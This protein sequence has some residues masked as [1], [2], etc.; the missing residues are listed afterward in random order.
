[1]RKDSDFLVQDHIKIGYTGNN[2]IAEIIERNKNEI[3]QDTLAD[4]VVEGKCKFE[5][6]WNINGEKVKIGVEKV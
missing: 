5:K 6:E 4:E 3:M 2:K 1:M